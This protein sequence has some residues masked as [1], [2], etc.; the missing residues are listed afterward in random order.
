MSNSV[1]DGLKRSQVLKINAA[2][3]EVMENADFETNG[4]EVL[5]K[6]AETGLFRISF[7]KDRASLKELLGIQ[8]T[9]GENFS[10]TLT[11]KDK[12]L[13]RLC[14]EASEKDFLDL[15]DKK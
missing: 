13:F 10:I 1:I 14:L 3:V 11:A 2:V 12:K 5:E 8:K 15:L 9:L 4:N 6:D 7:D